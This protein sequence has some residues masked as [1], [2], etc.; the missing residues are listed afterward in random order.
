MSEHLPIGTKVYKAGWDIEWNPK[1]FEHTITGYKEHGEILIYLYNGG[2]FSRKSIGKSV[3]LSKEE[4]LKQVEGRK[5]LPAITSAII[6][7]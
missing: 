2:G 7:R 6:R 4:A 1:A 5:P 3:Y